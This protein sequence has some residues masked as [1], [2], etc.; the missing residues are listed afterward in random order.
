MRLIAPLLLLLPLGAPAAD[1]PVHAC[2]RTHAPAAWRQPLAG[3]AET[4]WTSLEEFRKENTEGGTFL[5]FLLSLCDR[6]EE[7]FP[8]ASDGAIAG[9]FEWEVPAAAVRVLLAGRG[10]GGGVSGNTVPGRAGRVGS[11]DKRNDAFLS[12]TGRI[13]DQY[14]VSQLAALCEPSLPRAG[15]GRTLY[16]LKYDLSL[17]HI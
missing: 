13:L 5:G 2:L 6:A 3:R 11:L 7:D 12:P 10:V 16:G 17:I 4:N 1:T 8:L 14:D 15:M 9:R